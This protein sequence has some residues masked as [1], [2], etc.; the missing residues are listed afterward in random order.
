M[1][2][3]VNIYCD[4]STHLPNDGHPF[5]VLG[6]IV[7]P[8]DLTKQVTTRLTELRLKHGLPRD[9][10]IKW[11]KA[12]PAKVDFY[13]D[14]V[15]Y[16]FDDDDIE[17]R[18]VVAPKQGLDHS[19]FEQTHDDWYYKMMFYLVRNV[20]PSGAK[21]FIY[22]DKKDTRGGL[23]VRKL[24]EVIAAAKYDFDRNSIKRVQIVESHH[25]GLMQLAD[26][27]IGAVN[28]SNRGLQTNDAKSRLVK[29]VR[30]RSGKTLTQST[31]LTETKFNIFCWRAQEY[32][33]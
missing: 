23:K 7:C 26:L 21:S 18:A 14:V 17:F 6:A 32:P 25:V 8:V 28:Y 31:L 11:T 9:F 4:E 30:D 10:E 24:H 19:R 27:L 15:D 33:R 5:M 13:L 22:L 29:R 20:V 3:D 12:S 16:F 1:T 2:N